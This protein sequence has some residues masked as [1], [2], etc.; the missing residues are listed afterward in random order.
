[1]AIC[2]G[3]AGEL[4]VDANVANPVANPV[5]NIAWP[6]GAQSGAYNCYVNLYSSRV[7][8]SDFTVRYFYGN[9]YQE[10]SGT[11][12][13]TTPNFNFSFTY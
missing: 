8:S 2:N 13:T 1:M 12:S 4:D 10:I 9:M 3:F 6:A 5:E 7:G 11:V